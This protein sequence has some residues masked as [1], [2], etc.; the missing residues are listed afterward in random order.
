MRTPG[1]LEAASNA[2]RDLRAQKEDVAQAVGQLLDKW[3][4][5]Q[6]DAHMLE[7]L[8]KAGLAMASASAR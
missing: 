5:P 3:F 4:D 7:G 2:L 1:E 8:R 6:L